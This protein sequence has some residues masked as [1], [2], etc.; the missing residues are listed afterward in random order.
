MNGK[1]APLVFLDVETTGLDPTIHRAW[2]VGFIRRM[3]HGDEEY[4]EFIAY[5]DLQYDTAEPRAL[6]I[7]RFA[8]RYAFERAITER[9]FV[10]RAM[11]L[12]WFSGAII[13]GANPWFDASNVGPSASFLGAMFTRILPR[14]TRL[15][16][17]YHLLDVTSYAA[18]AIGAEPPYG[19][20]DLLL[21]YGIN[22][23]AA[24]RHTA[25]GDARIERTLYDAARILRRSRAS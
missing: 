13:I 11:L 12:G 6:E 21:A 23:P 4:R 8:E 24:E 14:G 18:G 7:G 25:L 3:P 10:H 17:D 15:P 20:D 1:T 22:P 19:L 16:W 5:F 2:E 9:E